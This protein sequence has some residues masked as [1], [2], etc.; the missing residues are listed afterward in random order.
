MNKAGKVW[1]ETQLI[2][3]TPNF[4]LHRIEIVPGGKCSKHRHLHKV[5]GFYVES[6]ELIIR[7]WKNDYDLVDETLLF[8]GDFMRVDPG[9]YHQFE[10]STGAVGVIAYE[11]Y[12][13]EFDPKDIDRETVGS[14]T[15]DN[16]KQ[17][18]TE[19]TDNVV[20]VLPAGPIEDMHRSVAGSPAGEFGGPT[21]VNDDESLEGSPHDADGNPI[22]AIPRR[23]PKTGAQT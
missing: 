12:W 2:C 3:Q 13:V 23:C 14:S 8:Q 19:A 7:V 16:L 9:E 5:N 15:Q 10:V 18:L 22:R 4:E 11:V 1:G 20:R 6:G 21:A 17:L